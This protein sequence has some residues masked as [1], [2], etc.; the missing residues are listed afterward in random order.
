VEEQKGALVSQVM[1]DSAADKA[2]LQ[3]GDIILSV[4]GR[5]VDNANELRNAIGLKRSGETVELQVLRDGKTRR[6]E[7]EL[8]EQADAG[9]VAA[10]ELH[11]GL[12]GA[13]LETLDSSSPRFEGQEGVLV[14]NVV[15]GSPAAQRGLRPGDV[16]TAVNRQRV[17]NLAEFRQAAGDGQSLLLNI[18]RGSGTLLLPIR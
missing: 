3:A 10:E 1:P 15:P 9:A 13:E 5:K 14:T 18:R 8:G 2:G 16:I 11:A 12:Q 17:G 6:L 4:D 7:A